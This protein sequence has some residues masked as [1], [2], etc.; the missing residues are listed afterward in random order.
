MVKFTVY[1]EAKPKGSTRAFVVNNRA[2]TTTNNPNATKWGELVAIS[3]QQHRPDGGPY[4]GAVALNVVFYF[5]R[6]KSVSA[7]KRPYHTVK[8]DLDKLVRNIGDALKGVIYAED[9]RIV[10]IAA[11][12]HY[13]DVPRVEIEVE[14][15]E[16]RQPC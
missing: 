9:A 5:A 10:R 4:Q 1:G 3:A 12:K 13:G 2:V 8:P 7:T 6:P 16:G 15:I 14:Q 11:E